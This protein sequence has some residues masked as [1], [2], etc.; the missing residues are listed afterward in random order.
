MQEDIEEHETSIAGHS[1]TGKEMM[2][3]ALIKKHLDFREPMET[4]SQIYADL[5]R[6]F[7]DF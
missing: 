5:K 4:Q 7:F 1:Q 2:N 3:V 6:N